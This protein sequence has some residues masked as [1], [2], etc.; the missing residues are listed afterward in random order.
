MILRDPRFYTRVN[1]PARLNPSLNKHS[2][3][4]S[5]IKPKPLAL[6]R[7][8]KPTGEEESDYTAVKRE[9]QQQQEEEEQQEEEQQEEEQQEEDVAMPDVGCDLFIRDEEG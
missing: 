7:K 1:Y 2:W 9:E 3:S 5:A 8:V 4:I 6:A